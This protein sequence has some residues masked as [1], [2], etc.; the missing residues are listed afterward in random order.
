MPADVRRELPCDRPDPAL[1]VCMAGDPYGLECFGCGAD[2]P[3]RTQYWIGLRPDGRTR[4][5][6]SCHGDP[7]RTAPRRTATNDP[8]EETDRG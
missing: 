5:C 3:P 8:T 6:D 2:I 4:A 1:W 7:A